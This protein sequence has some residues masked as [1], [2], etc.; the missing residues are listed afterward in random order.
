M[1]ILDMEMVS[2]AVE[3]SLQPED[4]VHG[5]NQ[6]EQNQVTRV[7]ASRGVVGVGGTTDATHGLLAGQTYATE[8]WLSLVVVCTQ[9]TPA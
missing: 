9:G 6:I 2:Q 3:G 5:A 8:W 7:A 4:V 1:E